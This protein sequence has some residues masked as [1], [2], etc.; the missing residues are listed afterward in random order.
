MW[1]FSSAREAFGRRPGNHCTFQNVAV[2][3][4]GDELEEEGEAVCAKAEAQRRMR[5]KS[6]NGARRAKILGGMAAAY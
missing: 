4:L 3:V 2:T 1:R 5:E 6:A